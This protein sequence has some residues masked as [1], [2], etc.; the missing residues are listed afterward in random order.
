MSD[1]LKEGTAVG[2]LGIVGVVE[3]REGCED[4]QEK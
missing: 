2:S 3:G 1:L 4:R